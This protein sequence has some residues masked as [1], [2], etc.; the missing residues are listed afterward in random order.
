MKRTEE[1]LW[2]QMYEVCPDDFRKRQIKQELVQLRKNV[3]LV[4]LHIAISDVFTLFAALEPHLA[5]TGEALFAVTTADPNPL[6][7]E[8]HPMHCHP[9]FC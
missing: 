8:G 7:L 6:L 3:F 2:M 5:G 9:F 4:F 1:L